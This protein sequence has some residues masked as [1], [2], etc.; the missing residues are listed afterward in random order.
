MK[1]P[2]QAMEHFYSAFASFFVEIF[3]F[4]FHMKKASIGLE[5][6]EGE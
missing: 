3:S 1:C 5:Q 4:V 6:Y 2:A